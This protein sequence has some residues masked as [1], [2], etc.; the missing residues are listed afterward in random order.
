MGNQGD[1]KPRNYSLLILILLIVI[2]IIVIVIIWFCCTTR[3]NNLPAPTGLSAT[4]NEST[5]TLNWN[6]VS[7]ADKYRVY[8]TK[9]SDCS[10][11][12]TAEFKQDVNGPPADV[13]NLERG[14]Y[15]FSVAALKNCN[16]FETVGCASSPVSTTVPQCSGTPDAPSNIIVNPGHQVG[17]VKV[18]WSAV[19]NAAGYVVY[20][21]ENGP[22]STSS[23]TQ[24]YATDDCTTS[25]TFVGLSCSSTQNF[26]VTA[27]NACG[28]EGAPSPV[29]SIVVPSQDFWSEDASANASNTKTGVAP[30]GNFVEILDVVP[31]GNTIV[32]SWSPFSGADEYNVYVKEGD[33]VDSDDN[34]N[35]QTLA[36]TFTSY[37]FRNLVPGRKYSVGV[38]V[39]KNGT[40]GGVAYFPVQL[41]ALN[42]EQKNIENIESQ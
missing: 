3:R 36:S 28:T 33:T 40:E 13:S 29:G 30:P 22:V 19:P 26:L 41:Q 14:T 39:T 4:T 2:A 21:S 12:A 37:T 17:Y 38:S 16:G 24:R 11:W 42:A 1:G 18:T 15:Y 25:V 27:T 5:V 34:D 32:L 6:L 20:R 23:Y 31:N 9:N 8:I 35:Y 7:G 10:D